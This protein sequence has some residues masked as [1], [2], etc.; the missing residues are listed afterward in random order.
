[1]RVVMFALV[2]YALHLRQTP[3]QAARN[4]LQSIEEQRFEALSLVLFDLLDW[5]M[6]HELREEEVNAGIRSLDADGDGR[7]TIQ[8]FRKGVTAVLAETTREKLKNR[9]DQLVSRH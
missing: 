3:V 1:M 8:E 5:D 4:S 2:A 6:D 9:V 7:V